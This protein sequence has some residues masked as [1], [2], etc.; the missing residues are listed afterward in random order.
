LDADGSKILNLYNQFEITP[1]VVNFAQGTSTTDV[2]RKCPEVLRQIEV[3][4]SGKYMTAVHALVSPEFLYALTS[5]A[6]VKV[7]YQRW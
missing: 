2:K 3:N 6:K 7:A 4:L 5:H 1:K